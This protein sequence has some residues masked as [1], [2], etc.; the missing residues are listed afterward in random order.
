MHRNLSPRGQLPE[1]SSEGSQGSSITRG[2]TIPEIHS[3]NSKEAVVVI[4]I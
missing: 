4:Y 3:E 2:R 1:G